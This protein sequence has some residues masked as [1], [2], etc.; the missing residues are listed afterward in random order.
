MKPEDFDERKF[1]L[2]HTFQSHLFIRKEEITTGR[3]YLSRIVLKSDNRA[4]VRQQSILR[5]HNQP[6]A[7]FKFQ[8][9]GF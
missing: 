2:K 7:F 4:E 5:Q 3:R 1:R 9:F 8:L 6:V